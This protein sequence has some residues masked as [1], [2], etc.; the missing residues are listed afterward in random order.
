MAPDLSKPSDS[1]YRDDIE[2]N[3]KL[4]QLIVFDDKLYPKIRKFIKS[5][6]LVKLKGVLSH[7]VTGHHHTP[8][9]ISISK[10]SKFEPNKK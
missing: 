10:I 1:K 9:L 2:K 3:L 7:S 8:V 6:E 5:K 4:I